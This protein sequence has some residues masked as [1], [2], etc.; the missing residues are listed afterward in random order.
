MA[1]M[2]EARSIVGPGGATITGKVLSRKRKLLQLAGRVTQ[3]GIPVSGIRV[4]LFINSKARFATTT[5]GN[6][7]YAFRLRNTNRRV[8]TT[9]FQAVVSAAARD[10]TATACANPSV[11][12]VKCVSATAGPFTARSKKLRVR[13]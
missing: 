11:T 13:L 3:G 1:G 4:R 5:Q 7:G 10:I 12:G 2:V 8:T 6:G 9:F